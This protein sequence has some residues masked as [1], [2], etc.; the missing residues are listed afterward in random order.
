MRQR[1]WLEIAPAARAYRDALPPGE[2]V[3]SPIAGLDRTGIPTWKAIFF[4][5]DGASHHGHSYGA[6]DAHVGA[7]GELAESVHASAALATLPRERGSYRAL[8]ATFGE[9]AVVDP[10]RLC[11]PAGSP[12]DAETELEWIAARRYGSDEVAYVP[13]DVVAVTA[14]DLRGYAAFATP[15]TN[16]LG[17]G[18]TRAFALAHGVQEL[19]QRDGNGV[20]FRAL[21]AGIALDLG[22]IDDPVIVDL[23][24]RFERA[25]IEP[26]LKYADDEFGIANVY[27]VGAERPGVAAPLPLAITAAG[28]AASPT[29]VVAM[30]KALLEFGAARA[31]K[32]FAHGPLAT[33]AGLV[34]AAYLA[35]VR[36][37]T[38]ARHEE[39]RALA[40]MLR[41]LALDQAALR[42]EIAEPILRVRERRAWTTLPDWEAARP[43]AAPGEELIATLV[44]R[45]ATAG[46]D[47]LYVDFT[48]PAMAA[49]G[50]HVVKAIVPGLEVETMSYYRIGERN[51]RKLLAMESPLVVRAEA[52]GCARVRL[53]RDA[54]ERIGGPAW[55]DR[56]AVDRV[57]GPLYAL[58]REPEIHAAALAREALVS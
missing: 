51:A 2:L 17:A 23:L 52:P 32:L 10:W 48:T 12:V 27:A 3:V 18:P 45:L 43:D 11:L 26:L 40:A 16:G 44:A 33:L 56:G 34:P 21:D 28:E 50:V 25:G 41:W 29:R 36:A 49:G 9:S 6:S 54:E 8:A 13:L 55:L 20:R 39:G 7:F 47:A 31:R 42:D 35:R 30:R 53:R 1:D 15:I 24:A 19:L 46:L 58:Y 38:D 5:A 4:A 14:A 57:V 37:G 22:G